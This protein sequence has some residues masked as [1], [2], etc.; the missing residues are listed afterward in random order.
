MNIY[1]EVVYPNS[2]RVQTHPLRIGA[3]AHLFGRTATSFYN[4]RILE[5]ACGDGG[6]IVNMAL[7]APG[8]EVVGID[9]ASGAIARGQATIAALGLGNIRLEAMDLRNAAGALGKFDY[10]IAHGLFAWVPREVGDAFWRLC[11]SSLTPDG[12]AFVSYNAL[13]GCHLRQILRD[14]LIRNVPPGGAI[15][16][17]EQAAGLLGSFINAWTDADPLQQALA[18][19]ARLMLA[20]GPEVMFHDELGAVWT[21]RYLV[22][23]VA[24]AQEHGLEYLCDAAPASGELSLMS[25]GGPAGPVD[26]LNHQQTQDFRMQRRFRQ[27]IFHR[28]GGAPTRVQLPRLGGLCVQTDL[29]PL[30][31][32][33]PGLHRFG[34]ASGDEISTAD[35]DFARLLKAAGDARPKA[36]PL[37]GLVSP[38]GQDAEALVQLVENQLAVLTTKTS[39]LSTTPPPW[40]RASAL[41]RWQL[42]QGWTD[43]TSLD[44]LTIRITSPELAVLLRKLDGSVSV[45]A[46][47]TVVEAEHQATLEAVRQACSYGLIEA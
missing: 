35:A 26:R 4:C 7:T 15:T 37:K 9:L 33:A 19:E 32:E 23:V 36:L 18:Q 39:P 25:D 38:A 31:E 12:L 17:S 40:P 20:R 11:E 46:L 29:R 2:P 6:N 3:L 44:H 21:P 16:R 14:L 28:A 30:V 22:D 47:G 27:S 10:I 43:V 42:A 34:R 41:A 45:D 5:V 13:P 1:D 24:E 8:S